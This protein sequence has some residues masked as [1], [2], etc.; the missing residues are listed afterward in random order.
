MGDALG[1]VTVPPRVRIL[2]ISN[3]AILGVEANEL[4]VEAA[5]LFEWRSP[6]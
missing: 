6:S 1:W 2:D 5:V 3:E 4:D